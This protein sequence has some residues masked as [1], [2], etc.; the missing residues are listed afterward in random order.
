MLCGSRKN[1]DFTWCYQNILVCYYSW[2]LT[3][4][5]LTGMPSQ[6]K[7]RP[8]DRNMPTQHVTTLLGATCCVRLATVLRCVATCWVL[9]AQ[10]WK[11]SNLSQQHPTSCN[12]SQHGGQTHA[13]H[14]E[15][16]SVATCCVG[17]LQSFGRG[18][19]HQSS[20]TPPP[21]PNTW[22]GGPVASWLVHSVSWVSVPGLSPFWGHF[23]V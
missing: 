21:P 16:K 20:A 18:L 14:V 23:Y 10:G 11:W 4:N 1:F 12:M 5:R 17:M 8:N 6:L 3:R 22:V 2:E 7:P 9:L 13:K 15:P 19:M